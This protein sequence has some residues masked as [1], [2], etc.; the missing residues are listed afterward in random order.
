MTAEYNGGSSISELHLYHEDISR[1]TYNDSTASECT[2]DSLLN[3]NGHVDIC[4]WSGYEKT[5]YSFPIQDP[6]SATAMGL[7]PVEF[8]TGS[9]YNPQNHRSK[10]SADY[11]I[12]PPPEV[13]ARRR[14]QNRASQN[15]FRARKRKQTTELEKKLDELKTLYT[16]LV[17]SYNTLQHEYSSVK[18]ELEILQVLNS[19]Q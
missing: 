8:D 17:Q 7:M 3:T 4:S 19:K 18:R 15:A 6:V 14:A 9:F 5:Q 13:Q 1:G 10:K 16:D 2:A 12:T 11:E